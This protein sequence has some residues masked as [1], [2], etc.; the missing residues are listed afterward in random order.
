[1]L[2]GELKRRLYEFS[3]ETKPSM[4]CDLMELY[5]YLIDDFVIQF[6]RSLKKK[7][8]A[9]KRED[10][11]SNRKGER[12]YLN[13]ALAKDL[14]NKLNSFFESNVEVPRI[15][16]GNKQTVETLISEEAL[17]LANYLRN[18]KQAWI[19]RIGSI[20]PAASACAN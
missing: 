14:M 5:R 3:P 16:H 11:S 20:V 9:M 4:V 18:E 7:D 15:R 6:C 2:F 10:Y 17:L 1:V 13:K 12:E 8:F 19:P